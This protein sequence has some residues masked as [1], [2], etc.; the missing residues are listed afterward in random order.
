MSELRFDGQVVIITGAGRG[1]GRS[2]AIFLAK[3][4]ASVVVNDVGCDIF[5]NKLDAIPAEEV[6]KEIKAAGGI[7]LLSTDN[8]ATQEGCKALVD[9]TVKE[10]GRVDALVHNAGINYKTPFPELTKH[11]LDANFNVHYFAA[12][13]LTQAA[14][15]YF[16]KQGGGA[17]LYMCSDGIFGNPTF[18]DYSS[19]KM[20]QVGLMRTLTLEGAPYGIK[21]NSLNVGAV[22]RMWEDTMA[23]AHLEWGR[24]YYPPIAVSQCVAWLIHPENPTTGEWYTCQ[25]YHVSHVGIAVSEGY[26]KVGFSTEDLRDNWDKINAW[27]NLKFP[28]STM[29]NFGATVAS[30]MAVGAEPMP[31]VDE[32]GTGV[33]K[34]EKQD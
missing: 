19:A 24:K 6:V 25:G 33:R 20:A 27:D 16:V 14:W 34:T 3:R 22:T 28:R 1:M 17:C 15:P 23:P 7:A 32:W 11:D 9:K 4:G 21:V 2:H 18:A 13:Y 30:L 31:V 12:V 29:E 8:V 10:F 5:G 26:S